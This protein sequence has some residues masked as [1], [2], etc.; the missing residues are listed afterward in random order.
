MPREKSIARLTNRIT[1]SS[2]SSASNDHE[3][4]GADQEQA[5]ETHAS[6]HNAGS[7]S[8]MPPHQGG[9]LHNKIHLPGSTR[10]SGRMTFKCNFVFP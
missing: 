1:T 5:P 7:S 8:A 3:S 9:S 2:S 10:L 4:L 6:T